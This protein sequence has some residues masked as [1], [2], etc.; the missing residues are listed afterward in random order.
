[1]KSLIF[2]GILATLFLWMGVSCTIMRALHPDMTETELFI[3]LPRAFLLLEPHRQTNIYEEPTKGEELERPTEEIYIQL[4]GE[5]G[6]NG[7]SI[8][9][10]EFTE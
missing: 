6:D 1:M 2:T 7:Q 9:T 10:G 3:N 5:R 4:W 8:G